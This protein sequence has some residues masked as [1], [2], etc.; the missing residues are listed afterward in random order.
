MKLLKKLA[1]LAGGALASV[2]AYIGAKTASVKTAVAQVYVV[3]G[4]LEVPQAEGGS[5]LLA[6][7]IAVA[8]VAVGLLIV[9]KAK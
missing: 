5:N 1:L 9:K 6:A 7:A 3:G 2:A 8:A 4:E